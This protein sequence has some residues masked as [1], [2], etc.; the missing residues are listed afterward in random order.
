MSEIETKAPTTEEQGL[1]HAIRS[2][3]FQE[4]VLLGGAATILLAFFF[5]GDLTWGDV[6]ATWYLRLSLLGAISAILLVAT[7]AYGARFLPARALG[8]LLI[9]CAALP[10]FGFLIDAL[11]NFFNFAALAAS[12]AMAYAGF[13]MIRRDGI[14]F[15]KKD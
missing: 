10:V 7:K 12:V 1:L 11:R 2:L 5:N 13:R 9:L 4:K 8:Q 6:F 3:P 14:T 15:F